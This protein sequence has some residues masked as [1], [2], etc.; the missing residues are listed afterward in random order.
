MFTFTALDEQQLS[1]RS[2]STCTRELGTHFF[3]LTQEQHFSL[4]SS[5]SSSN[6]KANS[7]FAYLKCLEGAIKLF[8]LQ[9]LEHQQ[10]P[11]GHSKVTSPAA[12]VSSC[13]AK[14]RGWSSLHTNQSHART[15]SHPVP[16][17]LSLQK[18]MEDVDRRTW[19][20]LAPFCWHIYHSQAISGQTRGQKREA[21]FPHLKKNTVWISQNN[22]SNCHDCL[23]PS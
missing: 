21:K 2:S 12:A 23:S 5:R 3:F 11:S 6:P 18:A 8:I 14:S 19:P 13:P 1:H 16:A 22:R 10:R 15:Q 9:G 17:T 7:C 4:I 20:K